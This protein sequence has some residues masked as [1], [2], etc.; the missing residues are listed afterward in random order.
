MNFGGYS[1]R[2][3]L[4]I[5][6]HTGREAVR[7]RVFAFLVV[8]ALA[9]VLGAH[10]LRDLHFGSPELKFI[11]DLGTGAMALFGAVLS[12]VATAK[13]F[14]DEIEH[15]T[16]LTL[17]AKPVCRGEVIVGKY[18]GMAVITAAFCGLLTVV[19]AGVLWA[20]ESSLMRE[21]PETFADGRLINYGHLVAEGFAQWL[22][23]AVLGALTLLVASFAES[24]L[25]TVVMAFALF[26]ICHL[27]YLARDVSARSGN[28]VT[29]IVAASVGLL[30]PNLQLFHFDGTTG[31]DFP[32]AQ[33][34]TLSSYAL[35]YIT[36]A[37]GL[38]VVS[39]RR[40]EI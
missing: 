4:H 14:F 24:Q 5:A 17:L 8:L 34:A 29:G 16:L 9:L 20:R 13:L 27:Q 28:P 40:R 33:L 1:S 39:F 23:L 12:V 19:L 35:G 3:V 7:Q 6:L 32:W 26:V 37:C 38:A 15:G 2:R 11:A 10:A 21:Y 18:L 31:G 22:K 36:A 30:L 25:F